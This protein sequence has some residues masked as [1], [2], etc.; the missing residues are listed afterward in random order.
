MDNVKPV[1]LYQLLNGSNAPHLSGRAVV[2]DR[3]IKNPVSQQFSA[4]SAT[5]CRSEQVD[6]VPHKRELSSQRVHMYCLTSG[7]HFR[8]RQQNIQFLL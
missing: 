6:A 5:L 2:A 8:G 1:F 7:P 3:R 4:H